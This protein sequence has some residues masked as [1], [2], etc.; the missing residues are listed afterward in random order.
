LIDVTD[1]G[2]QRGGLAAARGSGDEHDSLRHRDRAL[3]SV[4]ITRVEAEI[5]HRGE[6]LVFLEQ[7]DHTLLAVDGGQGRDAVVAGLALEADR[8][9][10]VLRLAALRD[11]H[12]GHDL[13]AR[14]HR[15]VQPT[16]RRE[17]RVEH[18]VDPEANPQIRLVRFDV[19]VARSPVN[20]LHEQEVA[21]R[22]DR[23]LLARDLEV[24][25]DVFVGVRVAPRVLGRGVDV[26][27]RLAIELAAV[28]DLLHER[29]ALEVLVDELR[30]V[31]FRA[32]HHDHALPRGELHVVDR[33]Q[34]E[35]IEHR[36][37]DGVVVLTQRD[38]LVLE[39]QL[40]RQR[41]EGRFVALEMAEPHDLDAHL[42]LEGIADLGLGAQAELDQD[43]SQSSPAHLLHGQ[44][45][46][47]AHVVDHAGVDQDLPQ[48]AAH[49]FGGGRRVVRCRRCR[50]PE[51]RGQW[52]R[53]RLGRRTHRGLHRPRHA[54]C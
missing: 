5:L 4:E 53:I 49:R 14:D 22:D 15:P 50:R 27:D 45:S 24:V 7:P 37:V 34:V 3:E 36:H 8:D 44:C 52:R 2:V 47:D 46:I 48:P 54:L 23:R 9:V 31:R 25:D 17:Q 30:E 18:A 28:E 39:H 29:L 20:R 10:S 41:S 33:G 43:R 38:R 19:D 21:K 51:A 35:R 26:L 12:I 42:L 6:R 13:H 40:A 11:V 1:T 32:R 16:R